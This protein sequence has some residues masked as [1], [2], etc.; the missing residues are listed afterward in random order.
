LLSAVSICSFA[1][2]FT[3][4][5]EFVSVFKKVQDES[6]IEKTSGRINL[7]LINLIIDFLLEFS[8]GLRL[9]LI[10]ASTGWKKNRKIICGKRDGFYAEIAW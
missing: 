6:K 7:Q 5:F 2:L 10:T 3:A 1:G 4:V 9:Y 8:C